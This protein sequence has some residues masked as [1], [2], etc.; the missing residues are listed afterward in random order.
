MVPDPKVGEVWASQRQL[1]R[2]VGV[3]ADYVHWTGWG[4]KKRETPLTSWRRWVR[5]A[6]AQRTTEERWRK[7][8]QGR[9]T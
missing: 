4:L 9:N 5:Q 2:V 7:L 3:D 8:R 6:G 1:R